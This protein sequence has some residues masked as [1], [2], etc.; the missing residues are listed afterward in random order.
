MHSLVANQP[1]KTRYKILRRLIAGQTSTQRQPT[2]R[3]ENKTDECPMNTDN[4]AVP[5]VGREKNIWLPFRTN[6]NL[7][8]CHTW[9][10]VHASA[11]FVN[12]R[13]WGALMDYGQ[14]PQSLQG[15]LLRITIFF[16]ALFTKCWNKEICFSVGFSALPMKRM[17]ATQ[18]F[19]N[20]SRE[21]PASAA[22]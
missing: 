19:R 21:P 7:W 11:L 13:Q 8:L 22:C 17:T 12:A 1:Q 10:A 18:Y 5:L 14:R 16:F 4:E 6:S 3:S 20:K 2:E 15:S 9:R